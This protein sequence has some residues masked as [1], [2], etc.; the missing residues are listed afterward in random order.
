MDTRIFWNRVKALAK[1]KK[2]TRKDV[3]EGIGMPIN[4][5]KDWM[6]KGTVPSLDY[7]IELSRYFGVSIQYLV[8]GK[9]T[10]ISAIS[11]MVKETQNSLKIIN[12]RLKEIRHEGK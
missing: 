10:E 2:A 6:Y 1:E 9:D 3:A 12:E 11:A 5:L 7:T 8:F 4:T